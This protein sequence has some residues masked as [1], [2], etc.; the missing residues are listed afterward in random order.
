MPGIPGYQADLDPYPFDL[1]GRQGDMDD[2][3]GG[4]RRRER[5]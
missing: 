5:G 4:P 3:P 1:D 2:G